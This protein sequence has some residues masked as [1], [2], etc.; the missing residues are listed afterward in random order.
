MEVSKRMNA[1]SERDY[2]SSA[3]IKRLQETGDPLILTVEGTVQAVVLNADFYQ[4]L[5]ELADK[6]R[7]LTTIQKSLEDVEQGKTQAMEKALESIEKK[8]EV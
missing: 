3:L 6:A 2:N 8:Y 5:V 1:I 4:Q 7:S